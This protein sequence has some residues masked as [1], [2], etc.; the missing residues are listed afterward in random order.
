MFRASWK[1]PKKNAPTEETHN[2]SVMAYFKA[3]EIRDKKN[4]LP[5]KQRDML[6]ML[7]PDYFQ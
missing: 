2:Y 4:Y 1:A 5:S 3:W 7:K 6:N